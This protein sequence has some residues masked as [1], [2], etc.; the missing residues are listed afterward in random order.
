MLCRSGVRRLARIV[1]AA[2]LFA[3][4]AV[5]AA[6]CVMPERS[7]ALAFGN[8]AA[9]PCHEAPPQNKNLC[10]ADCLSDDQ[11]ANTSQVVVP[12]WCG[13]VPL[14]VVVSKH[15]SKPVATLRRTSP[16]VAAPPPRILFQSFLI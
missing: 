2:L 13:S 8:E 1:L 11:S 10:L 3:Q 7:P 14:I 6:A 15:T 9:M 4:A 16:R 5:A 12:A